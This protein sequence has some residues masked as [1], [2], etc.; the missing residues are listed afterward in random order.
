MRACAHVLG[1]DGMF[2]GAG[3]CAPSGRGGKG[4]PSSEAGENRARD[5]MH[6]VRPGASISFIIY[7]SQL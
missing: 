1:V 4:E 3:L 6:T 2:T 5:D 7:S